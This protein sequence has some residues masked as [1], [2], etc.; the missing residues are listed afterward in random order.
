MPVEF[1]DQDEEEFA[2]AEE[3]QSSTFDPLPDGNYTVEVTDAKTHEKS[4]HRMLT[5]TLKVL[6]GPHAGRL[7]WRNNMLETKS[8]KEWLKRDLKVC[9]IELAKL[10]NI[11]DRTSELVGLVLS[12]TQKT[13]G[14]YANVYLNKVVAAGA[15]LRPTGSGNGASE[16]RAPEGDNSVDDEVPF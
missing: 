8:N 3:K 12:V 9:G 16:E 11:N 15:E 13:Q 4:G 10:F 2:E 6:D 1:S 14:K 7:L 5:W